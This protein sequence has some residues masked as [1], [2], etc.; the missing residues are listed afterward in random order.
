LQKWGLFFA[1]NLEENHEGLLVLSGG[2]AG[3]IGRALLSENY[4]AV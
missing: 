2:M 3:D 1:T 4:E